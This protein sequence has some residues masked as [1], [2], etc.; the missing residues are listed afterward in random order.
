[1]EYTVYGVLFLMKRANILYSK[2]GSYSWY[3]GELVACCSLPQVYME[4]QTRSMSL[5]SI[6]SRMFE[7]Q[8]SKKG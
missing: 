4:G 6:I 1:M 7:L 3:D 5:F 8:V 2:N